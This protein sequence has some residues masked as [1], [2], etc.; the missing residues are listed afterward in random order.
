[1][2][3]QKTAQENMVN[4]QANGNYVRIEDILPISNHAIRLYNFKDNT[5]YFHPNPF[6][7]DK[8]KFNSTYKVALMIKSK[9]INGDRLHAC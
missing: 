9:S 5:V 6:G 3:D 4:N 1:M 7:Y 8:C 2:R